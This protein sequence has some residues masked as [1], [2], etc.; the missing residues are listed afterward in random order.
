VWTYTIDGREY[1]VQ[2]S[3]RFVRHTG[4]AT[5]DVAAAILELRALYP[6]LPRRMPTGF[7]LD[8]AAQ[9]LADGVDDDLRARK[10]HPEQVMTGPQG[11]RLLVARIVQHCARLGYAPG[12]RDAGPEWI[13]QADRDYR[14]LLER[15]AIGEPGIDVVETTFV[16]DQSAETPSTL[17]R[18]PTLR[19]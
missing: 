6:D 16:A 2:D 8:Y 13:E 15:L 1:K 19:M 5:V 14:N 7:D 9:L 4:A 10:L 18:G 11:I 12:S 3:I 17:S